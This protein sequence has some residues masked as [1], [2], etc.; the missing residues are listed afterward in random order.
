MKKSELKMK[1]LL[2]IAVCFLFCFNSWAKSDFSAQIEADV[3]AQNSVE[4]KEKAMIEAQRKGFLEVASR[5]TEA[6]NVEKLN[7]LTDDEIA[8][9]VRSVSVA[10]E[11]AGGTKYK[12]LLT[13][14]I[15]NELLKEYLAENEMIE[16]DTSELAVVPVYR[17]EQHSEI[18]LWERA[19]DW[20]N[21]WLS[22]GLIK[23]GLMQVRTVANQF[24]DIEGFDA[25]GALYMGSGLYNNLS[26][27]VG[28]DR[29]YV[30]YA[31][32]LP[33]DDLKVTV[34]NE[35]NKTEDSFTV[36][37]DGSENLFDKAIEKSVMFIS[38][39]ERE[40]QKESAVAAKGVINAVYTYE[41]MKDWIEKNKAIVELSNVDSIDTKSMGA[42]KVNFDIHYSGSIDELWSALQELG[43]SHESM[44]NYVILR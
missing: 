23:F 9:F 28:T 34:K 6:E 27:L 13:V 1:K 44:N 30:V 35:K 24:E 43:I 20:R 26:S 11:K 32:V 17:P 22:K 25:Q 10:N 39:M 19:N 5:M 42:G 14:D 31:E 33:N 40:N 38:N 21:S 16:A 3:D 4:A 18:L 15:N 37:A 41:T 12:A 8:H 7:E 36:L 29:I 2:I